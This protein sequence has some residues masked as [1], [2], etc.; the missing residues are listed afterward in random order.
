MAAGGSV[1]L[2]Y[3]QQVAE[4]KPKA[5]IT[6]FRKLGRTGFDV[7][8]INMGGTR[9]KDANV[10]RYAYDHGVNYFDCAEVYFRGEGENPCSLEDALESLRMMES[11][12]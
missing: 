7:S 8:D 6:N 2:A 9:V 3:G 12:R 5:V 10:Y 1:S 11:V 4:E